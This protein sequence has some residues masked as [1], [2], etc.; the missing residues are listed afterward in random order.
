ML[1]IITFSSELYNII[2]LI[3]RC[4]SKRVGNSKMMQNEMNFKSC[5]NFAQLLR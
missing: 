2:V 3:I 5:P 4:I 1:A